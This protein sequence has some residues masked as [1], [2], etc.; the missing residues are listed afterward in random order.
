MLRCC[1]TTLQMGFFFWWLILFVILSVVCPDKTLC[2][3]DTTCCKMTNGTYGCCP[4]PNVSHT[5]A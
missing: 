4:M 5:V 1:R 2:P 3:D